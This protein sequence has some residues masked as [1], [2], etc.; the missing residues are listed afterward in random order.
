MLKG[1]LSIDVGGT[2]E[3][4]VSFWSLDGDPDS[5]LPNASFH[6]Y[7]NGCGKLVGHAQSD[8]M[9]GSSL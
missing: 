8:K 3:N 6:P 7:V 4:G 5:N 2:V 1:V 9:L